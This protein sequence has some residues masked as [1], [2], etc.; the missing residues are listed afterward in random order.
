MD[1]RMQIAA[2]QIRLIWTADAT[3]DLNQSSRRSMR[4]FAVATAITSSDGWGSMSIPDRPGYRWD[5]RPGRDV[6]VACRPGLVRARSCRMVVRGCAWQSHVLLGSARLAQWA[7]AD[8]PRARPAYISP[9]KAHPSWP[10]PRIRE[11]TRI[12]PS[13]S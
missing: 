12:G 13:E 4:R 8:R 9:S 7:A 1:P 2:A 11:V 3:I 10:S 6:R 5:G